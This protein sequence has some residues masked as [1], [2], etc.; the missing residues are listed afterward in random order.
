[1]PVSSVRSALRHGLI[2]G[3]MAFAVFGAATGVFGQASFPED[4]PFF[5]TT[6]GDSAI[7]G[8][9]G[10]LILSQSV[11]TITGTHIGTGTYQLNASQDYPR[12]VE[13]EHPTNDCAFVN[14]T[15][16]IQAADGSQI[17]GDLDADRSVSC[18]LEQF[19]GPGVDT[20]YLVT[21]YIEVTGGTGRFAD[22]SGWLF[23]RGTS[24]ADAPPAGTTFADTGIIVGDIDY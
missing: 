24:T 13:A 6:S 7:T 12:H 4:R 15:L 3:V 2:A 18:V 9:S 10:A 22:A 23:S 8:M 21:L 20:S 16:T 14:G 5:A 17:I 19:P 11:G 1:M